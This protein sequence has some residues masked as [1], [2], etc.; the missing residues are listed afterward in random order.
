MDDEPERTKRWEGGY[1]RT[2]EIL[3]EDESGSLKATIE[4]ILFKAKRKRLSDSH[5]Q[6]RLG[7]MRHLYVVVDGSRT[8]EDQDLKPNRFTCTLKL[9]EYF[10]EEYFDQNPISQ[11]GLIVTKSKRAEKMTELSGNSKKHITALKK[12]VDMNCSG[13]PSLYNSLNLAMQTLKHMPTH[14]SREVL[15]VFSSLTTCDPANIYDLI[16][17]LKAVKIRV[18]VIGLSA[19]VRVCTVLARETGGFPQHTTASA[20]DQ[21]AKPSFSMAQLENNNEPGLTLGGYFCPQCRAKYCEL[22]VECKICGL[23]LVS[24]PHLARSYHHLFP[25]DSFQEVSLEEYQGERYCQGCQGEITDQNVY[26][27]K[28]CQNGLCVECDLFVHDTLHCCPGCIHEHPVP[29]SL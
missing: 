17:C 18:S 11:I 23:T 1:E 5:G 9:L 13:E 14:T 6:V 19:E 25:L 20:S 24:A 26:I 10:V 15:V 3:K 22:P 2:W 4:D 8:M 16:K 12:A 27:C 29:V 7:M 28:V 21:D